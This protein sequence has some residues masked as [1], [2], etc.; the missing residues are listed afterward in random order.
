MDVRY[1]APRSVPFRRVQ[2]LHDG[3]DGK[4]KRVAALPLSSRSHPRRFCLVPKTFL[5]SKKAA[6]NQG[7]FTLQRH[8]PPVV[9]PPD[10]GQH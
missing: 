4:R 3:D 9:S 7:N 6:R 10:H 8:I 2:P 1:L 5:N